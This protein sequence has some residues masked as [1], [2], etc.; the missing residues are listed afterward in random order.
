MGK[1][2]ILYIGIACIA[3]TVLKAT[4]SLLTFKPLNIWSILLAVGCILTSIGLGLTK[5]KP[6]N[7]IGKSVN[8]IWKNS[9]EYNV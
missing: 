7:K 3:A 4:L 8:Q 1:K 2:T 5:L 6:W 9:K